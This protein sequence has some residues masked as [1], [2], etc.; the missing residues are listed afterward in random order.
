MSTGGLSY[1]DENGYKT[2][3]THRTELD[4]T[5]TFW[6]TLDFSSDAWKE[7]RGVM[8]SSTSS[9]TEDAVIAFYSTTGVSLNGTWYRVASYNETKYSYFIV[10][11][12]FTKETFNQLCDLP[13]EDN[14]HEDAL[15]LR[16]FMGDRFS[17]LK[18]S[19]LTKKIQI[20]V[21]KN[22]INKRGG[23]DVEWMNFMEVSIPNLPDLVQPSYFINDKRLV[24]CS[25]DKDGQAWIYVVENNNLISKTKI[26]LVADFWPSHCSFIP[27]LVSVPGVKREEPE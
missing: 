21:T 17:L 24:V 14:K 8:K 13:C 15:V 2:L 6:K 25:C 19:H 1:D 5:K 3:G 23:R 18:Q 26:D 22:K 4:P 12:D 20:W 11:F 16:V 7:Q 27:S 9:T 10:N